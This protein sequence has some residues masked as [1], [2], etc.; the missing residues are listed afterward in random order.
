MYTKP[1]CSWCTRARALFSAKGIAFTDID[2]EQV[3]GSR[4][5]MRARSG[6][7]TVPQIFI[8][9]HHVGGYEDAHALEQSGELDQLLA[10]TC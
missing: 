4:D 3:P 5:E 6:R 8:C 9:G 7:D 10:T 2:V 1:R